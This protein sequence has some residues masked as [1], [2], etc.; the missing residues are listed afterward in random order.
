[1]SAKRQIELGEVTLWLSSLANLVNNY[2]CDYLIFSL[3]SFRQSTLT[4][5]G[6]CH[7][8]LFATEQYDTF[9]KCSD[10]P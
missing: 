6:F 2:F 7:S 10:I 9:Y 4:V 5:N 8:E 1:M 3:N